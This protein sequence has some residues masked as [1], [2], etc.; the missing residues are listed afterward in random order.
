MGPD[1][2]TLRLAAEDLDISYPT[3]KRLLNER[4]EPTLPSTNGAVI[5]SDRVQGAQDP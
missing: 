1:G 2:L 4:Q 5:S 3:L